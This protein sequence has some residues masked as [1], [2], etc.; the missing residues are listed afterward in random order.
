MVQANDFLVVSSLEP[1]VFLFNYLHSVNIS[2]STLK[3]YL[4]ATLD[5]I[6]CIRVAEIQE[7]SV[8]HLD[9]TMADYGVKLSTI[10]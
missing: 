1:A 7:L 9:E 6:S 4:K 10:T 3:G 8:T 5:F 2:P